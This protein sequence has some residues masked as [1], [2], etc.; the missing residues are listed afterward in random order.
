MSLYVDIEKQLGSFR[1]KV[2]FQTE[3]EVFAI[4]GASGCGKSLTLKCIAGIEK[5]DRGIIRLD[6]RVLFDSAKRIDMPARSRR[7][8]YLFQDYALFPNMTVL[9]NIMCGTKSQEKAMELVEHFFLQGKEQLYPAQL[10]GGQK[11]RT[12]L[13]R[14]LGAKP[15]IIMLDEPFSALDNYLKTQLERELMTVLEEYGKPV[16]FVSHDRGEAYRLTDRIAV[17]EE[18]HI[19]EEQPKREL[20][21][22]PGTLAA[23]L[24]TGCKNITRLEKIPDGQEDG[25]EAGWEG[26]SEDG[27][28]A[29]RETGREAGQEA[30][31]C[32]WAQDW[33]VRLRGVSEKADACYAGF[34]AH[35]F[36]VVQ[37]ME[38][39]NVLECRVLRVIE[40][41]FSVIVLLRSMVWDDVLE[42]TAG[43]AACATR[44][45]VR[46]AGNADCMTQG[47]VR[48]A[49]DA[50][51]MTRGGATRDSVLTFE[52]PKEE[53]E[54]I[55][56][57][58][59]LLRIPEE[60]V[61]WLEK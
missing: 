26:M 31:P 42:R 57:E 28:E 49:G 16:L 20:F 47:G 50:A 7:V 24:L 6:D 22:H 33:G 23:A 35:Y 11:Q 56:G 27:Q 46:T 37:E 4:L 21:A 8:G 29:E 38:P 15:D 58:R 9:Q 32:Y 52:L 1:L 51:C 13:A 40:D 41:T 2:Q 19:V 30:A 61:I 36:Q 5:P 10:S 55:K 25:R 18:G 53:W 3:Q 43:D 34:R 59:L 60:Q 44:G 54:K 14:M 45:G 48:T 17:M 12:A 39:Y